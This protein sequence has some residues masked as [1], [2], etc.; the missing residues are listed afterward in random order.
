[1]DS[2][3]QK[4]ALGTFHYALKD[5]GYLLVGKAESVGAS[6][7]LFVPLSKQEKIYSRKQGP[8]RLIPTQGVVKPEKK[9]SR[10]KK[11]V[12]P[13]NMAQPDFRKSAEA[14]LVS[15]H[16][17]PSVIVDEHMEVVHISGT[18]TPF[19]E[20]PAG[21]PTFNL[22]KMAREGLGFELRNA[23][24]KS[25]TSKEPVKKTD[26]PIK[27]GEEKLLVSLEI[28]PL[29][30]TVDP[31]YLILFSRNTA[32]TSL[33]DKVWKK[34][35]QPP[36]RSGK[37]EMQ[38]QNEAMKKEL[39]Q[40]R[41]DMRGISEE[42]EATNEELQSANEELLSSNEEMQSLNEELETSK[43]ELQSTNEELIIINQELMDSQEQLKD[44]LHYTE[45]I[46]ATLREPLL[47]LNN[48]LHIQSANA[49]F[50]KKFDAAE[51]EIEGKPLFEIQERQWDNDKLKTLLNKIL[52]EQEIL[53][54]FE[55]EIDLPSA[56]KRDLLLNARELVDG[57]KA[58]RL[59]L[60]AM[61]DV[62]EQKMA[63]ENYQ[64]SISQLK[65]T[66]EQLD[67]FVHV[68]SHDLQ[69]PLRKVLTFAGRLRD[70]GKERLTGQIETYLD[71]IETSASRMTSL[72][73]DLL[74]YS[75][76]SEP[77][78]LFESTDLNENI[79]TILVD[80]ELLAEEKK[81]QIN[82][83][84]LPVIQAIPVQMNQ[85]FYNLIGNALKFSQK[86]VPPKVNIT[87]RKLT[88]KE[89]T[90]NATLKP[91]LEYVEIIVEDQGI[92]FDQKYEHQIFT[93]FQRL[94][95]QS[96][97]SGTG[98]GLAMVKRI[99]D[100]HQ[101]KVFAFSKI[102]EGAEFHIILPVEQPAQEIVI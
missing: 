16:T 99:V 59:I 12:V 97:Y 71:K 15:R 4:K 81:A 55:I 7:D 2:F 18:V 11:V 78:D 41:E 24:Y 87:S 75:R 60:F 36:I 29:P 73:K 43:E 86:D 39:A 25:K 72:N 19:L 45:A 13:R 88:Q 61:E 46:V 74:D 80:F 58:E 65:K 48:K 90:E 31:Y 68:A 76:L 57:K 37:N 84:K 40:V 94:N 98:I 62:T 77:I 64:N 82:V 20:P 54:D 32:R 14:V 1:M 9:S 3:L 42:Q 79:G 10:D 89:V 27:N 96:E 63:I 28:I 83:G 70:K 52:P 92:G 85:L 91:H 6:A 47:V 34:L 56:G 44:Y 69:E 95:Q 30:D 33:W 50:Y 100:N 101:G 8:G 35:N 102:G 21:K 22:L 66:N 53:H 17:P 5:H 49:A 26:I 38:L 51:R 93:I 23:L 67:Q